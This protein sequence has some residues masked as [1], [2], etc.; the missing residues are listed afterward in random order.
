MFSSLLL[1][2]REGLEAALVIGILLGAIRKMNLSHLQAWIWAGVGAALLL[3]AA[4]ALTLNAIGA[5]LEGN[6]E[7]VF[8]GAMMILA[9]V[10]LT[11]MILWMGRQSRY[12]RENIEEG[13]RKAADRDS[14]GAMFLVAFTAVGRE[15]IELALFLMA[16]RFASEPMAA[17][18]GTVA[19]LSLA[20]L[21]GYLIFA[22]AY[23]LNLQ[24]FFQVTNIIL[25]LFAAG[26]LGHGVH[27]FNEA[28]I[29]PP[30]I[31][32]VYDINM[33]L[34]ETSVI[35]QLMTSLFGYNG[36]PS[37]AEMLAYVLFLVVLSGITIPRLRT[38]GQPAR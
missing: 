35:G 24:R 15:G 30:G 33:L 12:L 20:V 14:R 9:A 8:E 36:N 11:W 10:L 29:I 19:G 22:S 31:E 13:V 26:L 17:L 32:H 3:S 7:A 34:P 16:A 37:L 25:V 1:A 38:A 5:E 2:L 21:L 28:G 4:A 6:A 18:L 23:R 27:E